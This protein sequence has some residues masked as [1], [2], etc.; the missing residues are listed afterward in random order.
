M[1]KLISY[2]WQDIK[3]L[4]VNCTTTMHVTTK[5]C[6]GWGLELSYMQESAFVAPMLNLNIYK[7]SPYFIFVCEN[8]KQLL[9]LGNFL[10]TH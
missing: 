9:N 1:E 8:L 4:K 5:R 3:D 7:H 6:K 2:S 10:N